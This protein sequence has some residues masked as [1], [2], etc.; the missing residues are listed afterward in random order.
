[1]SQRQSITAEHFAS[2]QSPPEARTG[3]CPFGSLA[4]SHSWEAG[5][6]DRRQTFEECLVAH[7]KTLDSGYPTRYRTLPKTPG[8][9]TCVVEIGL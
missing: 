9:C 2:D 5:G 4:E 8:C 3:T 1:M 6:L 7:G